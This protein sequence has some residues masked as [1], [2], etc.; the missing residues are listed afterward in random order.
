LKL[1]VSGPGHE[2]GLVPRRVLAVF[3]AA[4]FLA[5]PAAAAGQTPLS[6]R[7]SKALAVPHVAKSRS[8]AFVVDLASGK[9]VYA[10]NPSLPLIPASNEKLAVTYACLLA[11][12]PSFRFETDVLGEGELSGSVWR[13]DIILKGYGDPTLSTLDL[14]NLASQLH[15]QGI[16]R[17]AGHIVGDEAYFDAKRMGPGWKS[18][19]FI[20]ES[21]PL[22]ALTVDRALFQGRITRDPALAAARSFRAAL[23]RTGIS[24]PGR[25]LT[26]KA[27][28]VALPLASIESVPLEQILRFMDHESDNFTAEILLKQLGT[29]L[30]DQGTTATGA[31]AVRQLL[32]EQGIPLAGV[33]IAD[34][35]GLSRLDRLTT[36]SVVAMLSTNWLDEELR[37]ILLSALPVAGRSGTL[38]TRMRGTPAAGRVRAKTGTLNEASALSGYA[39]RRYAFSVIQNGSP[40]STYWARTAQDRF[41]AVLAGK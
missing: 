37:E 4:A 1:T 10:R 40:I 20:N 31:A 5:P 39:R 6:R 23:L 33:R 14:L 12:G 2:N 34:G 29:T 38:Q 28:E 32:A 9:P 16:R 11:F 19:F 15:A 17:I 22:S 13:G 35:S 30:A 26:G 24:V 36:S 27:D 3:L 8:A 18:W 25:A 7:L 21:A 41:A